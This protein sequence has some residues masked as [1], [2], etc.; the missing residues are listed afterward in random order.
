MKAKILV[1]GR[2]EALMDVEVTLKA[3]T[4]KGIEFAATPVGEVDVATLL[5][6][7]TRKKS[8]LAMA[9]GRQYKIRFH[10]EGAGGT[11]AS[12]IEGL[13]LQK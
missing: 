5:D 3:T 7:D 10:A 4:K 12:S 9:N 1:E 2:T 8:R 13:L 11:G 6:K